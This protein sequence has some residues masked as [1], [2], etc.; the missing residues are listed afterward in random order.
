[1]V[2]LHIEQGAVLDR[3]GVP[4]GVVERIAGMETYRVMFRGVSGH[5]GAMAMNDR[6]DP[7]VGAAEVVLGM[8]KAAKTAGTGSAVATVGKF[9]ARPGA[10]NIIAGEAE[11]YVDIRDSDDASVGR[12]AETLYSIT[13]G[14]ARRHG[15]TA[16]IRRIAK[17]PAI[18]LD[19]GVVGL[20]DQSA[21]ELGVPRMRIYSG[22]VHDSVMMAGVTRAGMIFV[23]S[24][25]GL[26]HCPEEET[27]A[28]DIEAGANVLL[29][30]VR[31]LAEERGSLI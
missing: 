28:A 31:R 29:E 3:L 9:T 6:R 22:A 2:E 5:A 17:S 26:S 21:H 14:S 11:F 8:Q 25:G 30:A 18:A 7:V 12:L 27:R 20:I 4:V 23:P 1:M 10:A 13:E 24:V 19:P 15:L 16:D